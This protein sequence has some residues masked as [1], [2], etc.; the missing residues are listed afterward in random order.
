MG[1]ILFLSSQPALGEED[2]LLNRLPVWLG[3]A[4][5]LQPVMPAIVFL[6][7]YDSVI[8]HLVEYALL[9]AAFA[10]AWRHEGLAGWRPYLAAW[11]CAV[12]FGA[13]DET[14]QGVLVPNRTASWDDL[15]RDGIGAAAV[16]LLIRMWQR[17]S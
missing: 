4:P 3:N 15:L 6:D 13:I 10:F 14:Y 11:L 5:W 8:G 2:F 17:D 12:L 16:V 9:G 7:E 1:L